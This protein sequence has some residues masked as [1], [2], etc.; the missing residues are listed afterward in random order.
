MLI[1]KKKFQKEKVSNKKKSK[2]L[3]SILIIFTAIYLPSFFYWIFSGSINT[4]IIKHGSIENSVNTD[5][6]IVRNEYV[7]KSKQGGI[8]FS[9]V[10]EGERVQAYS[11][12]ASILNDNNKSLI[13]D[14]NKKEQELLDNYKEIS[15]KNGQASFEVQNIDNE[16]SKF[17]ALITTACNTNNIS[18][19]V[20]YKLQIEALIKKKVQIISQLLIN[21][22]KFVKIKEQRSIIKKNIEVNTLQITVPSS[23][24]VSYTVDGFESV[25]NSEKVKSIKVDD[26]K[27]ITNNSI[28]LISE[29]SKIEKDKPFAKIITD[30]EYYIL[31]VLEDHEANQFK[32]NEEL[33][34]RIIEVDRTIYCKVY[35][36]S[37]DMA[38]KKI[39]A[40]LVDK[41]LS[42]LTNR[43]K[44]NLNIIKNSYD[45]FKIPV[46]SLVDFDKNSNKAKVMIVKAG[47]TKLI[48][49]DILGYNED[50][51]IIENSGIKFNNGI[52]LYD[53]FVVESKNVKEGQ[54]IN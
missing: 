32:I 43:R 35:N 28:F 14:L 9:E 20:E 25:F 29:D 22:E 53:T 4:D 7:I 17:I 1:K 46:K 23:G 36:V 27:K 30:N 2:F 51:A 33:K 54:F 11:K 15:K 40:V 42:E 6:F 41:A 39:I 52:N 13:L 3:G 47:V 34:I 38:G 16:I 8:F 26:L 19:I 18:E 31:F 44:V 10:N 21:D 49:V 5:G 50:F 12:V 24:M 45:G 37:E 48:P